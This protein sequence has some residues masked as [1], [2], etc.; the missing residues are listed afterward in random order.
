M[1]APRVC[2][3]HQPIDGLAMNL[4]ALLDMISNSVLLG[5]C[6]VEWIYADK[7]RSHR[8]RGVGVTLPGEGPRE[9]A[10]SVT[11][12]P[13]RP[14]L[15]APPAAQASRHTVAQKKGRDAAER[16]AP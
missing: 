5:K 9:L 8:E 2:L 12:G 16:H 11:G 15:A 10:P 14:M 1:A 6:T 3:A 13:S 4:L 7:T